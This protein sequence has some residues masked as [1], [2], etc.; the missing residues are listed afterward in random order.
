MNRHS[1]NDAA[2]EISDETLRDFA[3]GRLDESAEHAI[4]ALLDTR[5]DL[6]AKIAAISS[7]SVLKKLGDLS[8]IADGP[9]DAGEASKSAFEDIPETASPGPS[10][11]LLNELTEYKILKEIG[12]GGMGVVYLAEHLLTRRKEVLKV[13]NERL[14]TN[15][16]ARKRFEQEITCIASMNHATIVR[17]YTVKQLI[18]TVV[19]CMEYI[20]GKNLHQFIHSNG[21]LPVHLACGI[22]TEVCRGLQHAMENDLV[23]RDIKPSNIMLCD[24]GGK[25]RVKILDFGLAR[26]TTRERE[27]GLTDNG[28]LLGTLEYIAP[29]QCLNAVAADIRSDIYSLGCTL[30]HMLVGHPP[31]SGSTGELVLAHAQ[32]IPPAIN[33]FRPEIPSELVGVLSKLLEKQP[34][35]RFATPAAVANELV[36]FTKN[37]KKTSAD[38]LLPVESQKRISSSGGQTD[39][40]VESSIAEIPTIVSMVVSASEHST[41]SDSAGR[42]RRSAKY[43]A[44]MFAMPSLIVAL[45]GVVIIKTSTGTIRISGIPDDAQVTFEKSGAENS[46]VLVT[47]NE[48]ASPADDK[49]VWKTLFDGSKSSFY[50]NW[51]MHDLT[52]ESKIDFDGEGAM[53]I[54]AGPGET[55]F[56]GFRTLKKFEADFHAS[57]KFKNYNGSPKVLA[58]AKHRTPKGVGIAHSVTLGGFRKTPPQANI[59]GVGSVMSASVH[60]PGS[61]FD[62]RALPVDVNPGQPCHMEIIC[63]Q[64]RC[65][66]KVNGNVVNDCRLNV[67][68]LEKEALHFWTKRSARIAFTEIRIRHLVGPEAFDLA[69]N[70]S[71][72]N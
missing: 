61:D 23:H 46:E 45:L 5:P 64:S 35:R 54:I 20:P 44:S 31:F 36:P 12:R 42:C 59:L 15:L 60:E 6:A 39:T 69:V 22:A 13:L 38:K 8:D 29:E 2:V 43:L 47:P 52:P 34:E 66:V 17:C 58:F 32:A 72:V 16:A 41:P 40:S 27:K 18:H 21:P 62:Q 4:I 70:S 48:N 3:K 30:Y 9:V 63:Y 50:E 26:L 19:L 49:F 24:V 53:N 55:H 10:A 33:L 11:D 65:V 67:T 51:T 7:D 57:L 14:T 28:T 56:V 71:E 68:T 25:I 1:F 37:S